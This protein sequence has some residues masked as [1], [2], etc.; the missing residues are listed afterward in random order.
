MAEFLLVGA[1]QASYGAENVL[2]RDSGS[3]NP[4]ESNGAGL[5]QVVVIDTPGTTPIKRETIPAKC[6]RAGA[7]VS[8]VSP[9]KTKS[10]WRSQ[11]ARQIDQRR[12]RRNGEP[13]R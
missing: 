6:A 12:A 2:F 10:K 7:S 4:S 13:Q 8:P 11:R 1:F 3:T 5:A 9:L